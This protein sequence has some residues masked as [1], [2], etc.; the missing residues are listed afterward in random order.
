MGT[1]LMIVGGLFWLVS[2]VCGIIILIDAFKNEAWKGIAC[3]FCGFYALYYMFA[4]FQHE[5]KMPIILGTLV[6]G[7]LGG[8][9]MGYGATLAGL[10]T[11]GSP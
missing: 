6:S 1:L 10:A 4:E 9:I 11:H 7:I 3:I 2:L 5:Y 8:G